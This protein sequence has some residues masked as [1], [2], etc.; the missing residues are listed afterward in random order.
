VFNVFG[1]TRLD[2]LLAMKKVLPAFVHE[3]RYDDL[4]IG[5]D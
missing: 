5:D 2:D 1:G 3:L 4:A